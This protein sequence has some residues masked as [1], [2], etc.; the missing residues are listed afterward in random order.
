MKPNDLVICD[1]GF[2]ALNVLEEIHRKGTYFLT[3]KSFT[4]Q[5]YDIHSHKRIDL[6][7]Q[8][9]KKGWMDQEVLVGNN[10]VKM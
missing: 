10:K 9:K 6:A 7:K 1:M 8:L 4:E 2:F 3:R 5:I